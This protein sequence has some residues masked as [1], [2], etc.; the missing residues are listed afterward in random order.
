MLIGGRVGVPSGLAPG[1]PLIFAVDSVAEPGTNPPTFDVDLPNGNGNHLDAAVGDIFRR[2]IT[3]ST[4]TG[5]AAVVEDHTHTLTSDDLS[6][7]IITISDFAE[8]DAGTYIARCRLERGPILGAWSTTTASFSIPE[9]AAAVTVGT[10]SHYEDAVDRSTYT[11]AA[12]ALGTAAADRII[13]LAVGVRSGQGTPAAVVNGVTATAR[14]SNTSGSSRVD[15][16]TAAVPTD[17][18]GDIVV[19]LGGAT[20][21][22]G[23]GVFPIYGADPVPADTDSSDADPG[24]VTLTVPFGGVAIGYCLF[25]GG[26]S[27]TWTG[28]TESFDTAVEGGVIHSGA[29]VTSALGADIAMQSDGATA[30]TDPCT[31]FVSFGRA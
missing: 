10:I 19:T 1:T 29:A 3:L 6:D 28:I 31:L 11:F 24:S 20:S 4:D 2:Q 13:V 18:T 30:V 23:I 16:L 26:T 22:C 8:P 5:F 15:I 9:P 27:V 17:A 12:S 21:R 25:T 14:A 7:Y